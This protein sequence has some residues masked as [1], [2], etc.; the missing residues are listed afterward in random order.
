MA[1]LFILAAL[2]TPIEVG[3]PIARLLS[4]E[5][6]V[7]FCVVSGPELPEELDAKTDAGNM[8]TSIAAVNI[9][10]VILFNDL[11]ICVTALFLVV[12]Y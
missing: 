10:L 12:T 4:T 1:S 6:D 7:D 2:P 5:N 11:F 8:H 3:I 9:K